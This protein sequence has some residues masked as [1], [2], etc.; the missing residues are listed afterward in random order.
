MVC[1][2]I[3]LSN[4][5]QITQHLS[6]GIEGASS[7]ALIM[8]EAKQDEIKDVKRAVFFAWSRRIRQK[9]LRSPIKIQKLGFVIRSRGPVAPTDLVF[10]VW[11]LVKN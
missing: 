10:S 1:Y 7:P 5:Y 3:I 11:N 4:Y 2:L 9:C 8:C 6:S